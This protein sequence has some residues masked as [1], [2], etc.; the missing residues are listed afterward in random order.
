MH[1]FYYKPLF[2]FL[3]FCSSVSSRAQFVN[4]GQDRASLRW[5]EINTPDFQIIYP[6]FF[7][8]NAQKMANIYT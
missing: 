5:K 6:D 7:E 2:I 4:F 3:L 1:N 8:E